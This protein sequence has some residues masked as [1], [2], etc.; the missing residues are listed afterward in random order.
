MSEKDKPDLY[1]SLGEYLQMW[2]ALCVDPY[3]IN[4]ERMMTEDI[5][6]FRTNPRDYALKLVE[7][8]VVTA[9]HLLLSVLKYMSY[10]QVRE[11]LDSAELSPRLLGK[12]IIN[13]GVLKFGSLST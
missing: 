12:G 1:K 5:E 2:S 6:H 11:M 13:Q 9:D 3:G 8:E 4:E 10:N 7:E